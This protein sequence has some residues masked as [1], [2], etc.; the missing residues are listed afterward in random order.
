[1]GDGYGRAKICV[2]AEQLLQ[3]FS[4]QNQLKISYVKS[5]LKLNIMLLKQCKCIIII[6][7]ILRQ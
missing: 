7:R 6:K 1:M 2:R 3:Y 5:T 4:L